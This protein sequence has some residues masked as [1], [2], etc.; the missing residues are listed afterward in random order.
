MSELNTIAVRPDTSCLC[1][2]LKQEKR[3][4]KMKLSV[5]H[6]TVI[7]TF[8]EGSI[9]SFHKGPSNY[10]SLLKTFVPLRYESY[11]SLVHS[12]AIFWLF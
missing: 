10:V 5:F 7:E 11:R 3:S 6:R 2:V 12:F 4:D 8:I 9:L 1:H